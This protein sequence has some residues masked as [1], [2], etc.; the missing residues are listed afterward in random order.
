MLTAN[1]LALPAHSNLEAW[2]RG[3]E[4]P[5]GPEI[6]TMPPPFVVALTSIY[7]AFLL[8]QCTESYF[9]VARRVI[10]RHRRGPKAE[11]CLPRPGGV[12]GAVQ[13]ANSSQYASPAKCQSPAKYVPSR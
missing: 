10:Q 11:E 8:P 13:P 9:K 1:C 4:G 6:F 5:H 3:T 12:V 7:L 2:S